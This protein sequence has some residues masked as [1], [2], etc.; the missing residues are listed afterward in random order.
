MF[1]RYSLI[2]ALAGMARAT[3]VEFL[4]P[5]DQDFSCS[6]EGASGQAAC[7]A[8][9]A[10]DQSQCVWC[11]IQ[12]FGVCVSET[13]AQA[14]KQ[15]IPGLECDDDNDD[16]MPQDDDDRIPED[17]DSVPQDDDATPAA[18]DDAAPDDDVTPDDYWKCLKDYTDQSSC[19]G[20]GCEWCSTK[21][22]YG[23]CLDKKAAEKIDKYDWFDCTTEEVEMESP[24]DF[25]ED[26][27]DTSCLAASLDGAK[28]ACEATTDEDGNP[29][30][31]CNIGSA[32]LCL[33]SEQAEIAEQFGGTCSTDLEDPY[34]P[35]C[36]MASLSGDEATCESTVDEDGNGC[37]WCTVNTM[38]LCLTAEQAQ[39]A[40]Q[41][42]GE[43]SSAF[44]EQ[45]IVDPYDTSCLQASLEGDENSC[46]SATDQEGNPCD[47]CDIASMGLCLTSEQ[48]QI[49]ELAGGDCSSDLQMDPYDTSCLEASLEGDESS[50]QSA[51]DSDGNSCEWCS[52]ASVQ[53]CLNGEQAQMAQALGGECESH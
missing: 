25:L 35:S 15:A 12:S 7:D 31:W 48:A 39:I 46:R 21:A 5:L 47:W 33:T 16:D 2:A 18:D 49:A 51:V 3:D 30:E 28:D 22:G 52:V 24:L 4:N 1:L 34:D 36:L 37:E 53:L 29:C 42:G 43:C 23:I 14:M 44:S 26:P 8:S 10:S 19:T 20:G 11:S 32:N 6:V 45:D 38:Q 17:D 40:E 13:Q 41:I 27:Y 9:K 50:C